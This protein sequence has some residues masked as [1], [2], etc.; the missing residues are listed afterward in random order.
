MQPDWHI[1]YP[2]NPITPASVV[3]NALMIS[4]MVAKASSILDEA[5]FANVSRKSIGGD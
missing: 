4:A 3:G 5:I 2:S 1:P